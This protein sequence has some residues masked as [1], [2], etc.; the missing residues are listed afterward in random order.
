[1]FNIPTAKDENTIFKTPKRDSIH[2]NTIN[3]I[4]TIEKNYTK[5]SHKIMNQGSFFNNTSSMDP[6][7]N[8]KNYSNEKDT[9]NFKISPN[10]LKYFNFKPKS[11]VEGLKFL[12]KTDFKFKNKNKNSLLNSTYMGSSQNNEQTSPTIINNTE[13]F[14]LW[15]NE[16]KND[17]NNI[18]DSKLINTLN[19]SVSNKNNLIKSPSVVKNLNDKDSKINIQSNPSWV[20]NS[21]GSKNHSRRISQITVKTNHTI[22]KGILIFII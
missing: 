14:D 3:N 16:E 21:H 6:F 12:T 13:I 4:S 11:Q 22:E 20:F 7:F 8:S 9:K 1:M 15:Q 19:Q 17:F 5:N 18:Q 10:N 2:E